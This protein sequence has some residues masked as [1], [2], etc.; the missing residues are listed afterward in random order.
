M[1]S[2]VLL[3]RR[4]Y[5][6]L[7]TVANYLQSPLLLVLRIYFFWQLFLAGRGKLS[8][9]G[10]VI[11]F[12]TSLGIPAP[13][14]NAYFV[15][16]LECFGG[17][18]L[19]VGLA[20]RPIAFMIVISMCVAYIT[21]DSEA[22]A[23]FFSDPDKFVKADPFPYL[24]VALIIFVFGPGWLSIDALLG[25]TIWKRDVRPLDKSVTVPSPQRDRS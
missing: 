15:S 17:L 22:V 14:V 12:F 19:I 10:K 5:G 20:S 7:V 1:N 3:V 2:F 9:M 6:L 24:L 11:E 25:R 13:A 8:N 4:G 21:A 16:C 18:L 23:S